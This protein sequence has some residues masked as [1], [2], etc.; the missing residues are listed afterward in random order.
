MR[1]ARCLIRHEIRLLVSLAL[2]AGRRLHG[3]GD[4]RA[5]GYAR[6]QGAVMAGFGFVC[7]VETFTMS[8]LL[9]DRPTAHRVVLVLDLYTLLFL[10]GLYAAMAVRPHVLYGDELR[11]RY[12]GHV[13]LRIPL[14]RIAAVRRERVHTHGRA[15][16]ELNLA[17]GSQTSL[18]LELTEPVAHFTLLGGRRYLTLVRL[19]ADDA[20][21][22]VQ[23]LTQALEQELTRERN[24][25]PGAP[26]R[27]R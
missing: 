22:L 27:P 19:H 6:G 13:D 3:V 21:S 11:V 15:D 2:W 10:G 23:A 5:F 9:R 18:T 25:P 7:L 4:G 20:D 16:G 12:A 14:E 8:V 24:A 17:V 1:A 26:D